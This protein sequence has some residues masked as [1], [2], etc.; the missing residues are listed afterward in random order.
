MAV[1]AELKAGKTG[2]QRMAMVAVAVEA[3]A[4]QE[5]LVIALVMLVVMRLEL[6]EVLAAVVAEALVQLEVMD[7]QAVVVMAATGSPRHLRRVRTHTT[8]AAVA[9]MMILQLLDLV[10][11]V[12]VVP[13]EIMQEHQI[14]VVEAVVMS[15]EMQAGAAA[16]L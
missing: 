6:L 11:L 9:A 16:A 5:E 2:T 10:D 15:E 7:P 1:V 12:V 14:L 4:H 13:V 3:P 8:V